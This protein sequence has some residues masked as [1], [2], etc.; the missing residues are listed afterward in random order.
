MP[1][2][3]GAKLETFSQTETDLTLFRAF[4]AL[5]SILRIIGCAV[6]WGFCS[7]QDLKFKMSVRKEPI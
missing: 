4:W 3:E 2:E 6:A 7:E 5:H 1:N